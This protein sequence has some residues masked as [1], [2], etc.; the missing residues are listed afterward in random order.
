MRCLSWSDLSFKTGGAFAFVEMVRA[1]K[2]NA[3]K[4]DA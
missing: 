2:T 4:D 1:R 3:A